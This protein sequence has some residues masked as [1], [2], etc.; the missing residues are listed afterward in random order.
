MNQYAPSLS[1]TQFMILLWGSLFSPVME[2]LLSVVSDTTPRVGFLAPLLAFPFLLLSG[3]VLLSLSHTKE[4]LHHGLTQGT[5]PMLGLILLLVYLLWGILLLSLRLQLAALSFRSVGYKEGSFFFLLPVLALFVWWMAGTG[6]TS[7]AR[8][9]TFF[10]AALVVMFLLVIGLSLSQVE[11]VYL[12]PVTTSD[13]LPLFQGMAGV[14]SILGYLIFA[15]FF[16]GDVAWGDSSTNHR[17]WVLWCVLACVSMSLFLLVAT[18]TFGSALLQDM[19]DPF[20]QLAKGV[21][22]EG[23]FQRVESLV[24]A[25]WTL[26]DFLLMGVIL[27]SCAYCLEKILTQ[28]KKKTWEQEKHDKIILGIIVGISAMI[29]LAFPRLTSFSE[30]WALFGN[31]VLG[32]VLPF[33]LFFI[34]KVLHSRRKRDRLENV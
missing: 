2:L 9:S 13:V 4:G 28:I 23:G 20:F 21:R 18:G 3:Y 7:F 29:A 16:I 31:L 26:A 15:T 33:G 22:V 17:T 30:T 19:G 24:A 11:W 10:F 25:V 1:V 14:L 12:L 34:K 6:L 27:R 5:R 8:A 32:W